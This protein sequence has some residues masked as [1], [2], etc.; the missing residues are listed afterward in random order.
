MTKISTLATIAVAALVLST[1]LASADGMIGGIG[2]ISVPSG[3]S[4]SGGN[5]GMAGGVGNIQVPAGTQSGGG[6][7]TPGIDQ[8]TVPTHA[9]ATG[10]P[11]ATGKGGHGAGVQ[12]IVAISCV[13]G[14][15][16][17]AFPNDLWLTN[18]GDQAL[19]AG[20]KIKFAVPSTGAR[21]ALLL[22]A[23]I[24][25][26]KQVKIADVLNG[27]ADAGAPCDAKLI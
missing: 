14:G 21:G 9:S 11:G 12:T 7:M 5:S 25:A 1:S 16:P 10:A 3:G 22:N 23:D 20:A 4:G 13:V 19:K 2:S 18:R 26:G 27:G 17:A 6:S 8:I 24:P 15:T